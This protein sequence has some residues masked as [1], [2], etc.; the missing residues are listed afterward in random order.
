LFPESRDVAAHDR[1]HEFE[2]D[3]EILVDDDVPKRDDLRPRDL[4]VG[5]AQRERQTPA[6]LAQQRQP[7]Q[8]RTLNQNVA[9]KSLPAALAKLRD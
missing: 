4:G 1:P 2:L 5:V 6:S 7:V 9:E 3:S 8:Y